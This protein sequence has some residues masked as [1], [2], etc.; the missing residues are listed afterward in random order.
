VLLLSAALG[1]AAVR[2]ANH[3]SRRT[4]FRISWRDPFQWAEIVFFGALLLR[5]LTR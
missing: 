1:F 3:R 5:G 2:V 4:A